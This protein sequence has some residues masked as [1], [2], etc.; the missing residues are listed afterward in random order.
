M[1]IRSKT[2]RLSDVPGT[3]FLGAVPSSIP[4]AFS[5]SVSELLWVLAA[6][7]RP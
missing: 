6:Q 2:A 4:I 1:P 5:L 7:S 3:G